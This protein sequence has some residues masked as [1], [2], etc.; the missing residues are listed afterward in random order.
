MDLF[1][2]CENEDDLQRVM[3]DKYHICSDCSMSV[4][5]FERFLCRQSQPVTIGDLDKF[6]G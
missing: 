6:E 1:A 2:K 4:S 3:G 5:P